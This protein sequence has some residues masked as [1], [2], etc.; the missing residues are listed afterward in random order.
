MTYSGASVRCSEHGEIA[1]WT[2]LRLRSARHGAH[3]TAITTKPGL[4]A[5]V[6]HLAPG[7]ASMGHRAEGA[8]SADSSMARACA[9]AA[10]VAVGTANAAHAHRN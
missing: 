4:C 10:T 6:I 8:G 3:A 2:D 7:L 5:G 9:V 1:M